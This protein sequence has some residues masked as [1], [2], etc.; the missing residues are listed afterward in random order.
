VPD[1]AR[2]FDAVLEAAREVFTERGFDAP[3]EDV[4]GRADVGI[5]TLY[6]NFPTREVLVE[7]VYIVEIK[8]VLAEAGASL[9]LSPWDGLTSWRRRFVE[10]LGTKRAVATA[11]DPESEVYPACRAALSEAGTPLLLFDGLRA[12]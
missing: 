9:E 7:N 8:A 1:A 12:R 6:R 11:I 10:Y 5:A 2:N 3:L 4:A